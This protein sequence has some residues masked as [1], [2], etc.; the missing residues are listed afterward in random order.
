MLSLLA[1]VLVE[2]PS[3]M[4]DDVERELR[5]YGK[6]KESDIVRIVTTCRRNFSDVKVDPG[7]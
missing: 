5:N 7:S 6:M 1:V 3:S 2:L 4:C